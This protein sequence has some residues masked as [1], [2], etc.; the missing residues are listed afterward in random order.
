[1]VPGREWTSSELLSLAAGA[2]AGDAGAR[3][4]VALLLADGGAD[5]RS[6]GA[7][8][9]ELARLAAAGSAPAVEL[10]IEAIDGLGLAR[11]GVRGVLLDDGEA[12]D[13]AQDVLVAVA[14]TIGSFRGESQFST[15]LHQVARNKAVA[16]LRLRTGPTVLGCD[17]AGDSQRISSMIASRQ[18]VAAAVAGLPWRYRDAV[19]LRDLEG[20]SYAEVADRL[21][22]PLN[23]ARTRIARGRAILAGRLEP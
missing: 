20:L 19:V 9:D 6:T 12:E 10:L 5:R 2:T 7:F 21:G 8:V 3:R 18:T 22:L 16:R 4:S 23:T 15:W 11:S 17:R 13:A 14:E 1:M